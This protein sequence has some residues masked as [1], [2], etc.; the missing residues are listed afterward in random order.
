MIDMIAVQSVVETVGTLTE[1][2]LNEIER[3]AFAR[4]PKGGWA[5]RSAMELAMVA[6]IRRH[7]QTAANLLAAQS[8]K[9]QKQRVEGECGCGVG[10]IM[11]CGCCD[12][13]GCHCDS[14][15]EGDEILQDGRNQ[16]AHDIA[17]AIRALA[18]RTTKDGA[19]G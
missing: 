9:G 11:E 6:E 10:Y 17:S 3:D 1:H 12:E 18:A 5:E 8:H 16:A 2:A 7:R 14:R 4:I 15:V 19:A 13:D